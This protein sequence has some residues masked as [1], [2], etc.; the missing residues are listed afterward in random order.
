MK[1]CNAKKMVQPTDQDPNMF[2]VTYVGQH[3]CSTTS[4]P[5]SRSRKLKTPETSKTKFETGPVEEA[6]LLSPDHFPS[7]SPENVKLDSSS[8]LGND[9]LASH[10]LQATVISCDKSWTD[11]LRETLG[12]SATRSTSDEQSQEE[13]EGEEDEEEE[14][15]EEEDQEEDENRRPSVTS[16]L[17]CHDSDAVEH[18]SFNLSNSMANMAIPPRPSTSEELHYQGHDDI[19]QGGRDDDAEILLVRDSSQHYGFHQD[20]WSSL[21]ESPLPSADPKP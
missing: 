6:T 17:T 12:E 4:Q 11:R 8:T 1:D 13:E 20:L 2:E 18:S 21:M 7:P 16:N 19:M 15:E 9:E 5:R 14:E 3:T 10:Q